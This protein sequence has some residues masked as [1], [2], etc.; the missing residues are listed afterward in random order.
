VQKGPVASFTRPTSLVLNADGSMLYV[1]DTGNAQ[2]RAVAMRAEGGAAVFTVTQNRTLM[3]GTP[4]LR[5][6]F[7]L[8]VTRDGRTVYVTVRVTPRH[9]YSRP[10]ARQ[11]C[12]DETD[13]GHSVLPHT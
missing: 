13:R 5:N 10:G 7:D 12:L 9:T 1:T 8:S 6:P 4:A 3:G 11:R 2:L